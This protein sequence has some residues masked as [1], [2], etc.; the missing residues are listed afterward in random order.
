MCACPSYPVST[1]HRR[2][3]S[4]SGLPRRRILD[5]AVAGDV[6]PD[7]GDFVALLGE[8]DGRGEA[9]NAGAG[10]WLALRM[11]RRMCAGKEGVEDGGGNSVPD[12]DDVLLLSHFYT[13]GFCYPSD[14]VKDVLF[15][16]RL[17]D[18]MKR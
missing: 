8:E 11:T 14:L 12:D 17:I 9:C 13:V 3:A 1:S 15:V 10:E 6:C 7:D 2:S 4:L 16:M 18:R 5:A